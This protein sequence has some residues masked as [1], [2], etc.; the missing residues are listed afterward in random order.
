MRSTFHKPKLL[1]PPVLGKQ[2]AI[3]NRHAPIQHA[4][5]QQQP[6]ASLVKNPALNKTECLLALL[7]EFF[8]GIISVFAQVR[9]LEIKGVLV[10]VDLAEPFGANVVVG[11]GA[12]A[13]GAGE[14]TGVGVGEADGVVAAGGE[15][16]CYYLSGVEFGD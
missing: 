2:H 4:I 6:T 14:E 8:P 1:R 9:S 11:S 3:L 7:H 15:T 12:V 10:V 13:D 16:P 5:H